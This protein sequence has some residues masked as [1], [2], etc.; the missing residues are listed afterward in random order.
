MNKKNINHTHIIIYN[1]LYLQVILII[2]IK[3]YQYEKLF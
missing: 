3:H 2:I 1:N